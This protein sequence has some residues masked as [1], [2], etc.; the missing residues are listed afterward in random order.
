[1]PEFKPGQPIET[2]DPVIL[3][4]MGRTPL[5]KGRHTFQLIVVDDDGLQ[6][7]PDT[8]EVIVLDDRLPTAV[9]AAPARVQ[10]GTEFRLD[11]SRSSDPAPGKVVRY[12]WTLVS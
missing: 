5:P 1:M 7:A 6:S 2:D 12:I 8:R 11:G 4:E 3:V 9:L 10:L